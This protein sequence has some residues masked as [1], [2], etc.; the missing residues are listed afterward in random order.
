MKR[1]DF[2]TL[3]GSAAA[4]WPLVA[5]AQQPGMPVI[6]FVGMPWMRPNIPIIVA[7]RQGLAEAGYIEGR[8]VTIEYH[9]RDIRPSLQSEIAA[10]LVSRQVAVIVA[11]ATPSSALA[12]KAATST[13]P[14]VFALIDDPRKYGLVASLNRPGGNITGVNFLNAELAGKRL[15][16]LLELVP[17]TTTIAYL[18]GPETSTVFEDLTNAIHAAAR[19][20]GRDII[21]VPV[22]QFDFDSAFA[23]LIE[24][25]AGA[26]IVGDFIF[27]LDPPNRR[28]IL[29]LTARHKMP[30]IYPSRIYTANGGLMSYGADVLDSFRQLGAHYVG[31]I[32]KGAKPA[33]LPV[34]QPA[35]FELVINLKTAKALGFTIPRT[36]IAAAT[37]FIE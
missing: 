1:R 16:L 8:N 11:A 3:L 33:D 21:I 10:D 13:I 34:Q 15:N 37:D 32:L 24:R 36:L 27:F 22:R 26:L 12:A 28:K 5:H 30:A 17:Q 7:F 25:R 31:Q 6:G 20:L 23:N 2:I 29:D 18:S 35:K 4:S 19:A 9:L 14:I